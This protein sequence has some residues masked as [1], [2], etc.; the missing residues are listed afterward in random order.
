MKTI[1]VIGAGYWGANLVRNY[2]ELGALHS[3]CDARIEVLTAMQ[4]K[5]PM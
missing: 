1:A 4:K 3:V 2:F 5:F